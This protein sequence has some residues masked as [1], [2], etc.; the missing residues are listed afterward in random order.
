MDGQE[1][2]DYL[3]TT[4]AV[5][6]YDDLWV[7]Q[8]G[9]ERFAI[10]DERDGDVKQLERQM[11]A[12]TKKHACGIII[13]DVLTD[14]LRGLDNG[15]QADHL[16][17][18]KNLVKTGVTII[19]VL[20]TTKPSNTREGIPQ[21]S[22]EYSALG[23]STFVQSA[24]VNV[25][26]N[27]NK[28]ARCPIEKNTTWVDLPKCRGGETGQAGA[29]YYDSETRLVYDRNQYFAD[30]PDKLPEGFDLTLSSFDQEYYNDE[31]KEKRSFGGKVKG[32]EVVKG[33]KY[34]F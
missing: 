1:C 14:I 21:K 34:D 7:D 15:A 32:Q 18:Q 24:A 22:T 3:E 12:L 27:R 13:V 19:N 29:W 5:A 33:S 4:E 26:I 28:M 11:E 6:A 30:N 17:F 23:S 31:E 20:H 2:L 9:E 10:L 16:A 25:V 8:Y